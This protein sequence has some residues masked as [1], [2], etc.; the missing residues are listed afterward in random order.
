[1][2][3]KGIKNTHPLK[4]QGWDT[5]YSTVPPWL[6]LVLPLIDALT[7]APGG[8]FPPRGSKAVSFPASLQSLAPTGFSLGKSQE[9][10]SFSQPLTGVN[11]SYQRKKVNPC[12]GS[13]CKIM[14]KSVCI[15]LQPE[16]ITL[17]AFLCRIMLTKCNFSQHIV[18]KIV[19]ISYIL[20]ESL[21][22]Y[23]YIISQKVVVLWVFEEKA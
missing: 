22:N 7:G 1:M 10:V 21:H 19:E 5:K 20:D 13:F 4:A 12:G 15:I 9:G 18:F 16:A 17:V 6:Q 8:V 11:L 2:R 23:F 3:E 14:A